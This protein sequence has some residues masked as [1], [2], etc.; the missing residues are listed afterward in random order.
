MLMYRCL[1]APGEAHEAAEAQD[2]EL[3]G[4]SA[5]H[6]LDPALGEVLVSRSH[7]WTHHDRLPVRLVLAVVFGIYPSCIVF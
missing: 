2:G 1:I 4:S 5:A 3:E 7:S 6:Q